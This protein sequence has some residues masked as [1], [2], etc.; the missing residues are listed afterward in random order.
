MFAMFVGAE[1]LRVRS[2]ALPKVIVRTDQ[3]NFAG[4]GAVAGLVLKTDPNKT[5]DP[6]IQI[7]F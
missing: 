4:G 6:R 1:A 3:N 5:S 7:S 2:A